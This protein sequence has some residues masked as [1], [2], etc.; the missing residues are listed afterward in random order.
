MR[1]VELRLGEV[2][3]GFERGL[4]VGGAGHER[5]SGRGKFAVELHQ[6]LAGFI[7]GHAQQISFSR[8]QVLRVARIGDP[9]RL[10]RAQ[11]A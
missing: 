3:G 5:G 10:A 11:H 1:L 4:V 8:V 9:H 7:A 2:E 6:A